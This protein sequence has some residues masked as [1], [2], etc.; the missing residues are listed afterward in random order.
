MSL[1]RFIPAS[2][3]GLLLYT[4][5]A[6]QS[7][8]IRLSPPIYRASIPAEARVQTAARL[9]DAILVVWGSGANSGARDYGVLYS[10]IV[11][12]GKAVGTPQRVSSGALMGGYFQVLPLKDRFMV[13]WSDQRGVAGSA[14]MRFVAPDGTFL[15]AEILL[16]ERPITGLDLVRTGGD[17]L[18]FW[19]DDRDGGSI[20]SRTIGAD[21][22]LGERTVERG[23]GVLEKKIVPAGIPGYTMMP[24]GD[25]PPLVFD[26]QGK[27]IAA[28]SWSRKFGVPFHLNDDGSIITISH[29]TLFSFRTILDTVPVRQ[30][31]IPLA[32]GALDGS[33]VLSRGE[34]GRLQLFYAIGRQTIAAYGEDIA[35]LLVR[36]VES[37]GGTFGAPELVRRFTVV[38]PS[39]NCQTVVIDSVRPERSRIGYNGYQVEIAFQGANVYQCEG[40][41]SSPPISSSL[42]YFIHG[43]TVWSD[44]LPVTVDSGASV[45]VARTNG[46][47]SSAVLVESGSGT[48]R[49]AAPSALQHP[50]FP[51]VAPAIKVAGGELLMG[52]ISVEEDSI[53]RLAR[54]E[55]GENG[56]AKTFFTMSLASTAW[57]EGGGTPLSWSH[58]IR[59]MEGEFLLERRW[60]QPGNGGD[61]R[62]LQ[63]FAPTLDGWKSLLDAS[64][65]VS[66]SSSPV[67]GTAAFDPITK[68]TLLGVRYSPNSGIAATDVIAF[69]SLYRPVW[70]LDSLVIDNWETIGSIIP[71]GSK[72]VMVATSS[73]IVRFKDGSPI[74]QHKPTAL[75]S[76][77]KR[78]LGPYFLRWDTYP[79]DAWDKT[80]PHVLALTPFTLDGTMMT[81][82]ARILDSIPIIDPF[83]TQN[84]ADSTII[85]LIGGAKGVRMLVV[86]RNLQVRS[87][88]VY[89]SDSGYRAARPSG[90]FR[91]DTLFVVWEDYRYGAPLIYGRAVTWERP[92]AGAGEP[93]REAADAMTL[94]PVP[95]REQFMAL[96]PSPLR[97]GSTLE[98]ADMTGTVRSAIALD[99]G[100]SGREIDVSELPPGTYLVR[101]RTP[102]GSTVRPLVIVR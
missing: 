91:G 36:S 79:D 55:Y 73:T 76:S 54:W 75:A 92:V 83:V 89:V 82:R 45:R 102:R 81:P 93:V 37:A 52:W 14:Y 58:S 15:G 96:F 46:F 43:G 68:E 12:D 2:L 59:S 53:A 77:Y 3:L 35:M 64:P 28:G 56:P 57:G 49:L 16:H 19:S 80:D 38:R 72:D 66:T 13:F 70:R 51:Q 17:Q 97:S 22:A 24:H 85:F 26:A 9:G 30:I 34:D 47:D 25:G 21:G 27:E 87:G 29:D 42:R 63:V 88:L 99:E 86:D 23:K 1:L 61:E 50:S 40:I 33:Q 8:D 31:I 100:M 41:Y 98:I 101:L 62:H 4:N 65:V 39:R 74:A 7:A 32:S 18:L 11:R 71:V 60:K 67:L 84:P 6:A 90:V 78:L 20:Y 5:L 94:M 10:Q 48:V 95:A 69:D 44:S